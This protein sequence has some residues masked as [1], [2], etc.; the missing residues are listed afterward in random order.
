MLETFRNAWKVEELRKKIIY[1]LIMLL[2]YRVGSVIP[3]PGV[4][5]EYIASAV[6]SVSMLGMLDFINGQ[7]FSNFTIFAMGISPY[8]TSSI[9][10]Q[11]LCVAIPALENLQK[12]GEEGR[13]KIAQITRLVTIA[14]GCIMAIGII[15]GP[16]VIP[17]FGLIIGP[18]VG[19]L[20]GELITGSDLNRSFKS[21]VGALVGLFTSMVM[22]FIL[23][24]A[25]IILF[26]IWLLRW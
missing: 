23:Q 22:K 8:I 6:N 1:T 12:E 4:N 16:F 9:I 2:V 26:V 25:M 17:A 21:S 18:F 10:M 24:L 3:T 15:V 11:L 20:T 13:K 5:V 14:L 19:A 7:N